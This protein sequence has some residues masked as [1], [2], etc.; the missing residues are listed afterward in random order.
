MAMS[1]QQEFEKL[2]CEER[3]RI[4]NNRVQELEEI[5]TKRLEFKKAGELIR[6]SNEAPKEIWVHA[7]DA[8]PFFVKLRKA[9][10]HA[11]D[12]NK[13]WQ[14]L[15]FQTQADGKVTDLILKEDQEQ[16]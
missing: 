6:A 16:E 15:I 11:V 9:R 3:A 13:P 4:L 1:E 8:L 5:E 7:I 14:K 10:D 12:N 2:P